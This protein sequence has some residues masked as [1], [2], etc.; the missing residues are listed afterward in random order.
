MYLKKNS[1]C[2]LIYCILD[3]QQEYQEYQ[4]YQKL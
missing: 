2:E 4:E 1:V 3:E